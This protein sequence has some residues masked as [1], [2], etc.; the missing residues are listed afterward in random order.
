MQK[1]DDG[2]RVLEVATTIGSNESENARLRMQ[3]C[4]SGGDIAAYHGRNDA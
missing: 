1:L 4:G 3:V 2:R